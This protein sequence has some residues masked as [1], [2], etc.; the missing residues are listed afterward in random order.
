VKLPKVTVKRVSSEKELAQAYAIRIR[1]FVKEQGVP[2]EIE[3]DEDDRRAMHFLA[4]VGARAVGTARVVSRRGTAKI[5]RMAV[6]KSYRRR[7]VGTKL[8]RRAIVAARRM[9]ARKIYLH[10]QVAVAGFYQRMNFLSVGPVFDEAGIAHRKMIL[11][12]LMLA[13]PHGSKPPLKKQ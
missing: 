1:V 9:S 6:L 12:E 7:G 8:L 13:P 5:G 10:A 3:L 11:R 4:T 2:P